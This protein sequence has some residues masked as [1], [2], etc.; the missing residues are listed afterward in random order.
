VASDLDWNAVRAPVLIGKQLYYGKSDGTFY[1]RTFDGTTFG[2]EQVVDPYN[3]ATWSSVA[4]GSSYY[5]SSGAQQPI[6]YRGARPDFYGQLARMTSAFYSDNRLYYTLSGSSSLFYRAFSADSGIVYPIAATVPGV[7]LPPVTGAFLGGGSLYYVES[8]TGNLSRVAFTPGSVSAPA[9]V[10]GSPAVVSGPS[11]DGIDWRS[12]SLFLG[13]GTR[14]NTPPVATASASCSGLTCTFDGTASQDSDGSVVS[15]TWTFGDGAGASGATAS[16][17]YAAAGSYIAQ[18]TVTDDRGATGT[19]QVTVSPTAPAPQAVGF[20]GASAVNV[21]STQPTVTIPASVQPGD[22]LILNVAGSGTMTQTPPSGWT[23]LARMT[24]TGV[25]TTVWQRA[26]VA[27]DAGSK[28]TVVFGAQQ[29]AAV[30]LL[31]YSGARLIDPA[32]VATSTD[33]SAGGAHTQPALS[34]PASG[35]R[36]LWLWDVK[37]SSGTTTLT[38]PDGTVSRSASVGSGTGFMVT[39]AADSLQTVS[40]TVAGP[41]ATADGAAAGRTTMVALV[42]VPSA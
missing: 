10:G 20:R 28:V 17:T 34:A 13:T 14:P 27:G 33:A 37:A 39:L 1:R 18:L 32:T 9:T 30:S 42:I 24:P 23:Q 40:G 21:V 15:Y 25:L 6:Y 5:D 7:S 41:S 11:V 38:V 19:Q 4:S 3:D 29:K 16:H 31:A 12:G 26:A 36:A 22:L 35:S 2:P 8:G